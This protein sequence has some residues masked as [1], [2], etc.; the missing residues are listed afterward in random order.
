MIIDVKP[1]LLPGEEKLSMAKYYNIPLVSPGPLQRQ[2][3]DA[4]PMNPALAI[5]AENW[6]DLL[7][8]TGYQPVEYGYCRMPDGSAYLAIYTVYPNNCEPKMLAW[9]F[10]WLN[11]PPK[12]QPLGATGLDNIK[13]KIW[14]PPDHIGHGFINGKDR[15]DGI[16]TV[17]S[18]D[19]GA[20]EEKVFY[21][22]HTL[23]LKDCGLTDKKERELKA[24]G[25]WVDGCYE[26]FHKVDANRNLTPGSHLCLTLS[27]PC[28]T[29]G[30]EK[31][32]REWIGW[33]LKDGKP[34]RDLTT[35]EYMFEEDYLRK[36]MV[37]STVEAQQLSK[38]LPELYAEYH[39]KPDDT[40]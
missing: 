32:S 8:P 28:P 7:Q 24:A 20:G 5:K 13:Y 26:S 17:E 40:D 38:F 39:D 36:V 2:I 23:N 37:H 6:L 10:H 35:P 27:R 25:C 3:L 34:Y 11:V 19:L 33:G 12:S 31:I 29:G 14:C 15:T 30:M 4:G 9:W 22:R 18:L 21:I 1:P 16:W